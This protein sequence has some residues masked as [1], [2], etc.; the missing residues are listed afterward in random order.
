[1]LVAATARQGI[2]TRRS[3]RAGDPRRGWLLE[4][5]QRLGRGLIAVLANRIGNGKQIIC[6]LRRLPEMGGKPDQLPPLRGG[7]TFCVESTQVVRVRFGE[8][9]QRAENRRLLTVDVGERGDGRTPAGCSRT[10]THETHVH[11]CNRVKPGG[12]AHHAVELRTCRLPADA[13]TGTDVASAA[14]SHGLAYLR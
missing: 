1:M 11:D 13:V 14:R 4:T 6:S 9:R 10:P 12:S 3:G 5:R 7:E 2:G 8:G